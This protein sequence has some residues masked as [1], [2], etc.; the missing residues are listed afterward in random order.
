VCVG[1][2]CDF[3]VLYAALAKDM[4]RRKF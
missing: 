3:I 4:Y 1:L 2:C